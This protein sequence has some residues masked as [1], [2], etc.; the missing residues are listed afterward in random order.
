MQYSNNITIAY[1]DRINDG[2][3]FEQKT[4]LICWFIAGYSNN[5]TLTGR[6][7]G[8]K[9]SRGT[10]QGGVISPLLANLYLHLLDRS[11]E[12]WQLERRMS[13]RIVRYCDD[14]VVLCRRGTDQPMEV[15]NRIVTRLGLRLNA[16]KT[17][18]VNAFRESFDF[19]GFELRMRKSR[20]T[21]RMYP[22]V[23]PS[24]KSLK[25]IK[26]RIAK[27]TQRELTLLPMEVIMGNVNRTLRGWVNYFHYGNCSNSLFGLKGHVEER[28]RT[29][30]RKRHKIRNR[31]SGYKRF[32]N[33]K[34]YEWYGLYKVPTTAG[35]T[36]AHASRWRTSESRVRENRMHGLMREG[37]L[38]QL[39]MSYLGTVKRKG[40]KTDKLL[41]RPCHQLS[42]LPVFLWPRFCCNNK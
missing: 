16:E 41:L 13:A 22:H 3:D 29:H 14:I 24:R 25:T 20:S 19:L 5:N 40:R 38:R 10:P 15:I 17:H 36:K 30:L 33:R 23:Q 4:R 9:N 11:W 18:T 37:W 1:K 32:P 27:L 2:R 28:V 8:K 35:W 39:W 42:T 21:G 6:G 26:T 7:G 12:K 31:D 34:L